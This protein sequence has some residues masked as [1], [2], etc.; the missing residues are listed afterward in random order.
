MKS[1][2]RDSACPFN[3]SQFL[4]DPCDPVRLYVHG[5][6]VPAW[7]GPPFTETG[8]KVK[9][10]HYHWQLFSKD[11]I[12]KKY[13]LWLVDMDGRPL[14]GDGSADRSK[15]HKFWPCRGL[16]WTKAEHLCG[17]SNRT[18]SGCVPPGDA[19]F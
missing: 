6:C 18:Y 7:E 5:M 19:V 12:Y 14:F 16:A 2:F 9:G 10:E 17:K 11:G 15:T 13:N 1:Q 3:G 8:V 4:P